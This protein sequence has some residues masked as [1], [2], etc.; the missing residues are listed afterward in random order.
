MLRG[1][2]PEWKWEKEKRSVIL[3]DCNLWPLLMSPPLWCPRQSC[4]AGRLVEM[5]VEDGAWS[6]ITHW[7]WT[8]LVLLGVT[9]INMSRYDQSYHRPYRWKPSHEVTYGRMITNC[10]ENTY[11]GPCGFL[12]KA[13]CPHFINSRFPS[14]I[15]CES[16]Y[17]NSAYMQ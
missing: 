17:L 10:G 9:D 2:N 15:V 4:T 3:L 11:Q 16:Q 6:L 1:I 14:N 8:S 12:I 13:F 5:K 7:R